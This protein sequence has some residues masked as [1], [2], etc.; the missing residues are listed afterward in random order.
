[1]SARQPT[2]ALQ[3]RDTPAVP[4]A[5]RDALKAR[6]NGVRAGPTGTPARGTPKGGHPAG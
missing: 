4:A 6:R 1:M 2:D 5:R 3:G